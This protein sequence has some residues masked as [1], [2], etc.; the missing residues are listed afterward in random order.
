MAVKSSGAISGVGLAKP[1]R[2]LCLIPKRLS[3][4][5]E[6]TLFDERG[7]ACAAAVRTVLEMSRLPG[8]EKRVDLKQYTSTGASTQAR[9]Q[10]LVRRAYNSQLHL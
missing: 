1:S 10:C 9:A 7:E 5:D 2:N 8:T 3:E 4:L 6:V